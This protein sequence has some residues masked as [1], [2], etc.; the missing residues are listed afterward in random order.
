MANRSGLEV[1]KAIIASIKRGARVM[2]QIERKA[3]ISNRMLKKHLDELE[4]L[5]I[6]EKVTHPRHTQT[7]RPYRT[8]H[9]TEFGKT[10]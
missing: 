2:G 3:G 8:V 6:V 5:G 7:G 1:K 4:F 10:L 9:L